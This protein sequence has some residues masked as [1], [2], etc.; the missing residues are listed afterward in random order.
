ML[1]KYC[2]TVIL[3]STGPMDPK[4][5]KPGLTRS[6]KDVICFCSEKF[7]HADFSEDKEVKSISQTVDLSILNAHSTFLCFSQD[8]G[9]FGMAWEKHTDTEGVIKMEEKV[10][11]DNDNLHENGYTNAAFG[12]NETSQVQAKL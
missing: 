8:L 7:V 12:H 2:K 3:V 6:V 4:K 5:I 11:S 10:K 1:R 9:D